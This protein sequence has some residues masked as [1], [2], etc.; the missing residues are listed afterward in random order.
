MD[1]FTSMNLTLPGSIRRIWDK[2]IVRGLYISSENEREL[3]N[4]ILRH[5]DDVRK[6]LAIFDHQLTVHNKDFIYAEDKKNKRL[7]RGHEQLIV[8]L[9]VFFEKYQKLH[10]SPGQP[11]YNEIVL[12]S[13]NLAKMNMYSTETCEQRLLNVGLHDEWDI[14]EKVLKPAASQF[15]LHISQ[16]DLQQT[17]SLEGA[18]QVQFKFNAPVYRFIDMFSELA[19]GADDDTSIVVTEASEEVQDDD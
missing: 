18:R 11:W 2:L 3:Y 12:T 7:L 15:F 8:F 4:D 16:V 17:D 6:F 9:A 1:E 13:Q 10:S 14:F 19:E 5:E